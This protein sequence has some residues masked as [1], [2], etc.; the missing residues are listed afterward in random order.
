MQPS[1][2]NSLFGNL[3][4]LQLS[5][6]VAVLFDNFQDYLRNNVSTALWLQ[7]AGGEG[8]IVASKL[9]FLDFHKDSAEVIFYKELL[10]AIYYIKT[11][12][13]KLESLTQPG[14]LRVY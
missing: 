11:G 14:F 1:A 2:T 5:K 6:S 7:L 3:S 10:N 12:L 8:C 13:V 9:P 4:T